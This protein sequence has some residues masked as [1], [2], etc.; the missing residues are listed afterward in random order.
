MKATL[1]SLQGGRRCA[2][3]LVVVLGLHRLE[4]RRGIL[5]ECRAFCAS[6]LVMSLGIARC[7]DG[8]FVRG[9]MH[10]SERRYG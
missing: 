2:S 1:T 8:V 7:R 4:E 6:C 3:K 9:F 10:R 5:E